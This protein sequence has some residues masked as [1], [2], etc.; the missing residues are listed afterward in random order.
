MDVEEQRWPE[1]VSSSEYVERSN[2]ESVGGEY[3]SGEDN[4]AHV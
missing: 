1:V 4:Q 2:I 3:I